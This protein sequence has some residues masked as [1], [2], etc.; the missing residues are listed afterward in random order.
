MTISPIKPIYKKEDKLSF[1]ND[2]PISILPR[3]SKTLEKLI[4]YRMNSFFIK[5]NIISPSKFS[6]KSIYLLLIR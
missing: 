2:R 1:I 5:Y 4:V 6:F 3:D